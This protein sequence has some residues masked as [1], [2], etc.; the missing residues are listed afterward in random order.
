MVDDVLE[1]A[2]SWGWKF[3]LVSAVACGWFCVGFTVDV[4]FWAEMMAVMLLM[5]L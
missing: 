2:F 5:Q 4:V 1:G 3:L